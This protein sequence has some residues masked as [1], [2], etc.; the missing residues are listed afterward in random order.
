MKSCGT[1]RRSATSSA[2][3]ASRSRSNRAQAKARMEDNPAAGR[4]VRR[5]LKS[6]WTPVGA[7]V[8]T[9]EEVDALALY[10]LGDGS[11]EGAEAARH[12]DRTIGELPG[13]E[14][15]CLLQDFVE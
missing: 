8:K 10:L 14:G 2:P 7:G 6:F 13:L 9:Q 11:T 4:I 3:M 5:A 1:A 12:I 15:L